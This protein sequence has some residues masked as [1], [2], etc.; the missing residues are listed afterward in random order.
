MAYYVPDDFVEADYYSRLSPN[1]SLSILV[2]KDLPFECINTSA[3]CQDC[4]CEGPA[5][6]LVSLS[7]IILCK[8]CTP[9]SNFKIFIEDLEG[10]I[11]HYTNKHVKPHEHLALAGDLNVNVLDTDSSETNEFL[12]VFG[13]YDFYCT[14][15]LPTRF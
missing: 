15:Q 6:R 9:D 11:L 5:I 4:I 7:I 12:N 3:F 10:L 8:Y 2:K 13:S 14:N 1:S